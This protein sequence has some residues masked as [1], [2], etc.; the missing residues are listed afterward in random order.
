[1]PQEKDPALRIPEELLERLIQIQSRLAE[2]D[3]LLKN[4]AKGRDY[5]DRLIHS[6]QEL[7]TLRLRLMDGWSGNHEARWKTLWLEVLKGS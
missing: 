5:E 6:I 1:M 4:T 7:E 2:L 3:E